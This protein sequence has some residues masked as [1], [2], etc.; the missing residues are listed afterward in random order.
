MI[1]IILLLANGF[2]VASEY[3]LV[4]VRQTRLK[5]LTKEGN[6]NAKLALEATEELDKYIAAVQLGITIASIGLGWVGEA[7]MMHLIYPIVS[8]IPIAFTKLMSLLHLTAF[9]ETDVMVYI[10]DILALIPNKTVIT[11]H[12]IAIAISFCLI[13]LFHVVIGEL[14]P[15]SIALQYPEKTSLFIVRPMKVIAKI[16]NPFIYILNGMG[17]TLLKLIRIN[18]ASNTH[19][20]HSTEELNMLIDASFDEGVINETEKDMLQNVFKFSDLTAK[21]VMVPRTDITCLPSDITLNEL[22]KIT[23]ETQYTRYPVFE[24]DID[25]IIGIVHIKD[26]YACAVKNVDFNMKKILRKPMLI[27]ETVNIDS[28]LVDFKKKQNQMAIVI[29]EFGGTSGIITVEDVLEEIFGEVQDEFDS[30]EED[31]IEKL[32]DNMY[33]VNGMMRLDELSEVLDTTIEDDDVDTIG[34]FIVKQLGRFAELNDKVLFQ[35]I[36]FVVKGISKTRVTKLKVTVTPLQE[37]SDNEK[38]D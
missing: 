36:E 5:Q 25:N 29:D 10:R 34:G 8:F 22:I 14:M 13:T 30:D 38:Q 23:C 26:I 18:P 21:Q 31:M 12:S 19:L 27:P 17:N 24:E 3:A 7:A 35:N 16:F 9:F 6:F 37:E 15:K 33:E 2:F 11:A 32:S 20:A 28:L 4:S 1:V